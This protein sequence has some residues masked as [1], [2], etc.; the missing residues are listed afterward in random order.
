MSKSEVIKDIKDKLAKGESDLEPKLIEWF[1]AINDRQTGVYTR[2]TFLRLLV[3]GF[4]LAALLDI[5]TVHIA[6]KLWSDPGQAE[7]AARALDE[8]RQISDHSESLTDADEK[9]LRESVARAYTQLRAIAPPNYAWQTP[10]G[11]V[12]DWPGKLLGW[13]LTALAT[14]LGAQFWFNIMSES[15]KLRSV[16]RKPADDP[17]NSD[18]KENP[19]GAVS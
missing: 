6:G 10:P 8:V 14:S 19:N 16:G 5:D 4:F 9:K 17:K 3:I 11:K 1:K 13:L 2:W 12:D 15:L 18:G 7:Q